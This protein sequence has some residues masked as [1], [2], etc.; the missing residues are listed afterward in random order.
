MSK[1]RKRT[2]ERNP[3]PEQKFTGQNRST[4]KSGAGKKWKFLG[5]TVVVLAA[6]LA[7]PVLLFA[8]EDRMQEGQTHK[9]NRQS[10]KNSLL[11]M[12][13]IED[14]S[15][16]VASYLDNISQGVEYRFMTLDTSWTFMELCE[17]LEQGAE[18]NERMYEFL[19]LLY[20]A[21][22]DSHF[23]YQQYAVCNVSDY[24]DVILL[25]LQ[26]N[27]MPFSSGIYG[28]S[29]LVDS[30]TG[31]LYFASVTG[32][33]K[34]GVAELEEYIGSLGLEVGADV[35]YGLTNNWI[36]AYE[37]LFTDMAETFAG[38]SYL[39][40]YGIDRG[41]YVYSTDLLDSPDY[42]FGAEV[43]YQAYGDL[44]EIVT[45]Q[46]T[47]E[48]MYTEW[49]TV[50][51]EQVSKVSDVRLKLVFQFCGPTKEGVFRY[52]FGLEDFGE[53]FPEM[54]YTSILEE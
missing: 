39:E 2:G 6:A 27:Y 28:C 17:L 53:L 44:G 42:L 48:N 12:N 25:L 38:T 37:L 19:E 14:D 34:D 31:A 26:I 40:N 32:R 23:S 41:S 29:V 21:G 1:H 33:G 45:Q 11:A 36:R 3:E 47:E 46:R 5:I 20:T 7:A 49:I 13:Y 52:Y 51:P 8:L 35:S 50:T 4:G 24:N 18:K 22:D 30:Q 10:I 16:R 15:L 9:G 54:G 43:Y